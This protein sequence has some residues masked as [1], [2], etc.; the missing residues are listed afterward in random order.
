MS[1]PGRTQ[2]RSS[3]GVTRALI[4][5]SLRGSRAPI[6]SSTLASLTGLS[7]S[8]VQKHLPSLELGGEAFRVS[9]V[10]RGNSTRWSPSLIMPEKA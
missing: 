1:S 7:Q 3:P 8:A 5:E 2:V 9:G 6:S 10:G 4:L